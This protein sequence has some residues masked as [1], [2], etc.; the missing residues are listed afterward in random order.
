MSINHKLH[1]VCAPHLLR[2]PKQIM[3]NLNRT[4]QNSSSYCHRIQPSG[5]QTWDIPYTYC[6]S[7]NGIC[8]ALLLQGRKTFHSIPLRLRQ[9]CLCWQEKSSICSQFQGKDLTIASQEHR[10]TQ[11][12]IPPVLRT[13]HFTSFRATRLFLHDTV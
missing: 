7:Q 1:D 9:V 13:N 3:F 11:L 4:F 8:S 2:L 6:R 10:L 12:P 5:K